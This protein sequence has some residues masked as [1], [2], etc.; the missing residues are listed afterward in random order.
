V[1]RNRLRE[2]MLAL[3]FL[4]PSLVIL[5]V[6]VFYPLGRTIWLGLY[7]GG[8]FTG[9]RTYVGLQQYWDVF[10]SNEFR[11]ALGVTFL[12]ALITV[13]TGIALGL[14]LAVLADKHLRGMRFFRTAYSSTVAT[15]TA[16]ASLMWLVLFQ[17][18]IGVLANILP[19][20]VLKQPGL[21]QDPRWALPAL[22]VVSIWANAGFTF[23]IMTA[24]LQSIPRDL[25]E[26]AY[27]DGAGGWRRFTNLTVPL[28]G[29]TMLFAVVVLTVRALQ[30]YAE[31]D[32]LTGG[33]P[34]GDVTTT[35]TYLIYGR[36]SIIA[37]DNGLQATVA[38]LLFLIMLIVSAIQ[39]R[40]LE[41]RV[42]YGG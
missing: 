17:P 11:H 22:G 37:F 18:S 33:G 28:L 25:Y 4:V 27:V 20:S 13:P 35:V 21:L 12:F 14:G 16:V 10:Q 26:S 39:F 36:N 34:Q 6:F 2:A 15:S 41:R 40:G 9:T 42:H 31:I 30:T 29:P 23:I 1:S 24:G 19:F 3:V 8:G 38:V 32:I 5:G 7:R